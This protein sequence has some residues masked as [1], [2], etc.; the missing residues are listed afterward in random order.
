MIASPPRSAAGA[1][2]VLLILHFHAVVRAAAH[3]NTFDTPQRDQTFVTQLGTEIPLALVRRALP[4][5]THDLLPAVVYELRAAA[6]ARGEVLVAEHHTIDIFSLTSPAP[7]RAHA[8]GHCPRVVV[9]GVVRTDACVAPRVRRGAG[10]TFV[11]HAASG[12]LLAAW[13]P[14]L[15]LVPLDARAHPRVFLNVA[16]ARPRHNVDVDV[17]MPAAGGGGGGDALARRRG[18][19]HVVGSDVVPATGRQL[20]DANVFF[21]IL[22]A[23]D[24]S[25]C[26]SHGNDYTAVTQILDAVVRELYATN[27]GSLLDIRVVAVDGYCDAE[28]DPYTRPEM[29][30]DCAGDAVCSRPKTILRQF[31]EHWANNTEV[32]R[33]AAYLF[34]GYEDGTPV[35]G[36]AY[37]GTACNRNYAYGWIEGTTTSSMVLAHEIGHTLGASHDSAGVMRARLTYDDSPRFS[38]ASEAKVYRFVRKLGQQRCF[39][40]RRGREHDTLHDTKSTLARVTPTHA[41]D[42]S[43]AE[44]WTNAQGNVTTNAFFLIAGLINGRQRRMCSAVLYTERDERGDFGFTKTPTRIILPRTESTV[45]AGGGVAVAHIGPAGSQKDL[46]FMYMR[47]DTHG[48]YRTAFIYRR[49]VINGDWSVEFETPW[50]GENIT[51][52]GITIRN[53]RRSRQNDLVIA[54]VNTQNGVNTPGYIVG[55]DMNHGGEVEGGWSQLYPIGGPTTSPIGDVGVDLYDTTGNGHL[56]MIASLHVRDASRWETVI[57]RATDVQDDG[58]VA[59]AWTNMNVRLR[60][61][62]GDTESMEGGVALTRFG[63]AQ[64]TLLVQ[65]SRMSHGMANTWLEIGYDLLTPNRT[66]PSIADYQAPVESCES[67]YIGSN[68]LRCRQMLHTCYMERT[69]F[70]LDTVLEQTS[71]RQDAGGDAPLPPTRV[72]NGTLHCAGFHEIYV[73]QGKACAPEPSPDRLASDGARAILMRMLNEAEPFT[74]DG[75]NS[76]TTFEVSPGTGVSGP[77]SVPRAASFTFWTNRRMRN[78]LIRATIKRLSQR[79]GYVQA[80]TRRA[81]FRVVRRDGRFFYRFMFTF[82]EDVKEDYLHFLLDQASDR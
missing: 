60:H 44:P 32:H 8:G 66:T 47:N 35:I 49:W 67:C 81:R 14:A 34:T 27:I 55:F 25:F 33:D 82:T 42:I 58:A 19:G 77:N 71:A 3:E 26:A 18:G 41:T 22:L 57:L 38:V 43:F 78:R 17:P 36:A 28:N 45:K 52:V 50:L 9:N 79:V 53:I 68:I 70:Q 73:T 65:Q 23:F 48:L 72:Q 10:Y 46:T 11:Y 75:L 62:S 51:S 21:D 2:T 30:D 1:L 40:L 69:D 59:G 63:G 31:R 74:Y 15:Q 76:S 37:T 4:E 64:P 24:S 54:F 5:V 7:R 61:A 39:L 12:A 29:L 80:Y 56:D 20:R 6:D 13:G 16:A